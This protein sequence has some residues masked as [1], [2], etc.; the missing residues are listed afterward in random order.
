[1][2]MYV[3]VRLQSML[4]YWAHVSCALSLSLQDVRLKVG[5]LEFMTVCIQTQPG[6]LEIFLN[7][8]QVRL[9]VSDSRCER[10]VTSSAQQHTRTYKFQ[11]HHKIL[12]AYICIVCALT[13]YC[14]KM[15]VSK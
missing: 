5:I 2:Y 7:L 11:W 6:L 9:T 8:R 12:I 10:V 15:T 4:H 1:M 13:S 14:T 3:H